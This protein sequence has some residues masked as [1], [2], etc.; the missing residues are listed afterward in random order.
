MD[1]TL[2]YN[3]QLVRRAVRRFCWRTL[4]GLYL[5]ALLALTVFVIIATGSGDRSWLM[6]VVGTIL[7]GG[8]AVPVVLYRN[9]LSAA[10]ARF[11][12]LEGRPASFQATDQTV[13]IRSAGGMSE[14]PW[15]TITGVWQYDDCWLLLT[16]PHFMTFPLAGVSPAARAF[17]IDRVTANGGK[18]A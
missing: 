16:G 18:I 5:V 9:Q 17:L 15:R 12:A 2:H 13:T 6:G 1:E 7:V 4:G 8:F 3:E 10:L 11:R 14:F